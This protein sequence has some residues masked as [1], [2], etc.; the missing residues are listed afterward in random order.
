MVIDDKS[1]IFVSKNM[2]KKLH[3]VDANVKFTTL[4]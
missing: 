1:A 2:T 3:W 4:P